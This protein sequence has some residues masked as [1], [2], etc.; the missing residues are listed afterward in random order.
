M[1]LH[2][3]HDLRHCDAEFRELIGLHPQAHGVLTGAEYIDLSDTRRASERINM[4]D[5]RIVSEEL[6]VVAAVR[7]VHGNEHQGCSN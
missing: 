1:C 2:R 6:R 4:I 7:R 5:I 3:I